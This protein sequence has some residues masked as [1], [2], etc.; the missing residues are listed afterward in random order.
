MELCPN[1]E[2]EIEEDQL[3]CSVCGMILKEIRY[4][5]FA[6][7]FSFCCI[8]MIVVAI[9]VNIVGHLLVDFFSS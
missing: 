1:C 5:N 7:I 8:G 6:K 4:P 9:I 3:I 2:H